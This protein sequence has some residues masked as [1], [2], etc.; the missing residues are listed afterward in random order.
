MNISDR[1]KSVKS[2]LCKASA[3]NFVDGKI[4]YIIYDTEFG[5]YNAVRRMVV[6]NNIRIVKFVNK[7]AFN[8]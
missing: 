3:I 4:I 2:R 5:M 6:D 7:M 8:K 1:D